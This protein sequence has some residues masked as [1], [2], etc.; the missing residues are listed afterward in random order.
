MAEESAELL[1]QFF[2]WRR[3]QPEYCDEDVTLLE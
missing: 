3:S 2:R 1:R